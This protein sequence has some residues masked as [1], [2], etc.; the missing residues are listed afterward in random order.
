MFII[1]NF[2]SKIKE[3]ETD[4]I[5][6]ARALVLPY[7]LLGYFLLG[8]LLAVCYLYTNQMP[9]FIRACLVCVSTVT[10]LIVLYFSNSWRIVSHFILMLI[11]LLGVWANLFIYVHGVNA[12]TL[13]YVWLASALGFYMHGSRWGLFYAGLNI[14][15]IL[16]DASFNQLD[17][18]FF[19]Q[20]PQVVAKPIYVLVLTFDF[21][22]ISFLHY[23]FF[24]SFNGNIVQLMETKDQLNAINEKLKI[25]V[26][27][28]KE[29]SNVRMNF[30]S[31][32]SHELRTPLNGVVGLTNVLLHQH[33]RADQEETLAVLKFSAENLLTL[34]NDILD[35]NKLDSDVVEL[36]RIPFSLSGL[37]A[38]IYAATKL[39]AAEKQ[40]NFKVGIAEEL[41]HISLIGDPTRLTQVLLNLINNAIKFTEKGSVSLTCDS[42]MF[43]GDTVKVKF[44]VADTGIGIDKESQEGI[45]NEFVQA[46]KSITRNYGGTGLGLPIV[47]KV[48]KLH[49]SEIF[50]DSTVGG[51][52]NF[53]FCITFSYTTVLH[54]SDIASDKLA[55]PNLSEFNVLVVEDNSVNVMVVRKILSRLHIN[56]EVADNGSEAI[57]LIEKNSYDLILMDLYM[58]VLDGYETAKM[59]RGMTNLTKAST[60]IIA[61]TA[62]VNNQVI[63]EVMKAGMNAYL[64]KPFHPD[65]LF[66]G[67]K[68]VCG[69]LAIQ[70][71]DKDEARPR[72]MRR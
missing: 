15:P 42:L 24:K 68:K 18:F 12:A 54:E 17:Y 19:S 21:V 38:N 39:K 37:V 63:D 60:P 58:P 25:T 11:T 70:F 53:S 47:K 14:I 71:L 7:F 3:R 9:Q 34:V 45:F 69:K 22:V 61:L 62:T 13:Q 67:I 52:A 57:K 49:Q 4:P 50:V 35:F 10:L 33:P 59:I 26:D 5:N 46:S 2:T 31:T 56:P 8:I 1:S 27:E 28:I 66:A 43:N 44:I 32:M 29:L 36:E 55:L 30:L 72:L 20:G 23:Y 65:D 48:L 41:K 40:L 6:Q 16:I 64:S 51:G